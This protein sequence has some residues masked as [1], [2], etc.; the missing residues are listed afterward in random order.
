MKREQMSKS[1]FD[2]YVARKLQKK[3]SNARERG[4]GFHMT[5]ASMKNILSSKK[6]YY[7]GIPLELPVGG[8]VWQAA[9]A[10]TIDR[11]DSSKPYEKG[12]VVACCNAFNNMKGQAEAA[13]I[14][15]LKVVAKAFNKAITR[16]EKM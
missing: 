3:A 1:E 12:N 2:L 8:Q 13:G 7:T 15:G 6:C 11:I 9:N 14:E 5:F 10:L 16:M 4:I